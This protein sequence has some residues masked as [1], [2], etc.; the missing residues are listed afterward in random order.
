MKFDFYK[1]YKV[2]IDMNDCINSMFNNFHIKLN[3]N[4]TFPEPATGD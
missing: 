1:K 3:P 2:D 4:Y